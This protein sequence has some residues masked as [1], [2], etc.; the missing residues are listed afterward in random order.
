MR[1]PRTLLGGLAALISRGARGVR[2]ARSMCGSLGLLCA[3]A[4][5]VVLVTPARAATRTDLDRDWQFR[6]DPDGG[7]VAAGWASA[8]PSDTESVTLPHTWNIGRLHDYLGVAWYFRRFERPHLAPGAHVELHFG[9]TFYKARV[10]LNGVELGSHEGGFTAY[11]FD[12]TSSLRESNVLAVQIDNRPGIATIPAVAAR[13]G[14]DARYDW[15]TYG[16]VVRDVWLTTTGAAWVRRQE[17]R[18][19]S[20]GGQSSG[21]I[22]GQ[23]RGQSAHGAVVHDRIILGNSFVGKTPVTLR[24]TAFGPDNRTAANETRVVPLVRGVAEVAI[25]LNL[26]RPELWGIDHP[27]LYRM[28]VELRDAKGRILDEDDAGFGVR[29]LE[30]R[31]RHLLLNGERVRLTGIAR[32]EDSPWEGLAETPGTMRYDWDDMK[33]LHTTLTRPVHYPQN[34]FILDYADRHG[35]LLIPE[36]P[37]WQF[38]EAQLSDPRV[39]QLAQQQMREMIEEAGN[40]PSILGW[41]V[42]NESATGTPGGIAYFR[43]M[44]ALIRQL[45]PGRPVSFADD[46]LPKLLRADQSA[47]NDADFLMMNQYFGSWHG[48]AEALEPALDQINR[49]FPDKMV[50]ISEM[51]YAGVFA[52]NPTAADLARIR[53]MQ[54]QMPVLAARD[55]IAGAI[56]WC[57]QD[58][59][60]PRNLWPGETE[61]YVEHGLVDEDRQ[62]KPSYAVWKRLNRPAAVEARWTSVP[63]APNAPNIPNAAAGPVPTGFALAVAPPTDRNLPFYPL[64]DY[65]LVWRVVD[66]RGAMVTSGERALPELTQALSITGSLP[67]VASP[68]AKPPAPPAHAAPA[69]PSGPPPPVPG[70]TLTSAPTPADPHAPVYRLTVTLL[71]PTGLVGA[72]EV[73]EWPSSPNAQ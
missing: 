47:A 57:Y 39:L 29:T 56:L 9:A 24:V 5:A 71:G 70:P 68:I 41:S 61:G 43:A 36:I 64:H 25:S 19:E 55:W 72:E 58:Y 1:K 14:P 10:W 18:T 3:V 13:G 59:K 33:A 21:E 60:S 31:E 6:A 53:T 37:L 50:I 52:S 27:S 35:I 32:H 8:Q 40:H 49:L 20:T 7:G 11:S 30:I 63:N 44:R 28:E 12:I 26:T 38:S 62:R 67:A 65:R 23:D 69:P 22:G 2:R 54:E 4:M 48:P 15:W 34:P 42:A 66:A 51:G 17:I 46:N 16:G 73:L 45:D